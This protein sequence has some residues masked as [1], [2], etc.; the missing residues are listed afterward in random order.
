MNVIILDIEFLRKAISLT[1]VFVVLV[2]AVV[3][4]VDVVDVVGITS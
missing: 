1:L 2:F 3:V 4:T